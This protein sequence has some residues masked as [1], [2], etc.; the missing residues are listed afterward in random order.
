MKRHPITHH[1]AHETWTLR[2]PSVHGREGLVASHH[3]AASAAGAKV[4]AEGGNAVDAAVTA[5]FAIGAVEPWMSGLGGGGYMLVYLAGER[6]C[7]CVD[8]GMVASRGVDV[9][10]YPLVDGADAD[11]FGWPAVLDDRNVHGPLSVMVP[12]QVAGMTLALERFGTRKLAAAL[13]PAI[14]LAA[15]GMAVDWYATLKIAADAPTLARYPESARIYLPG[16]FAPA[17]PWGGALPR[18]ALGRLESTLRRLADAGGDDFYRGQIA[19]SI[20]ADA[21]AAGCPLDAGDL[22]TYRAR[23]TPAEVA[24][25]RGSQVHVAPGLTAGP[26]LHRALGLLEAGYAPGAQPDTDTWVAYARA[27]SNAYTERLRGMG[28]GHLAAPSCTTHL[29]VVDADGNMVA[30]TQTLLSVFGSKMVLPGTGILMNNGMMW[31]D[32][33]PGGPNSIAPGRRPLSNMCPV[34]AERGDGLRLAAG[35]SGGRRIMPAVFQLLS[36]CL[37][38]RMDL[39]RAVHQG[40]IDVSGVPW[41]GVDSRLPTGVAETLAAEFPVEIAEHGVYPAMFAC[42]NVVTHHALTGAQ[43]GGAYVTSPWAAVAVAKA[44]A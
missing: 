8:F 28:E 23:V 7:Y 27:L 15:A 10:A 31:F 9:S 32:P 13:A 41:V 42:P 25:Y 11:L 34:V 44:S 14:E 18:I 33:R 20:V 36:F 38:F 12:G 22:A 16:G 29:S 2:K 26:T 1:A 43:E 35:A 17:A 39:D 40:R 21:A 3:H 30:L 6:R 19:A 24:S 37:D 4:L 5:S